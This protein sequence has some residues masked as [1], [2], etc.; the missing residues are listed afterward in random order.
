MKVAVLMSTYNGEKFIV[1]QL[2]SIIDQKD[3]E[4]SLFI[5]DDGS[6][7][8][9]LNIIEEYKDKHPNFYIEIITGKNLGVARSFMFLLDYV[10]VRM[11]FDYFAFADQDDY[12]FNDKISC[13][14]KSLQGNDSRPRLYMS[15]FQMADVLLNKIE[16]PLL[17]PKLK[18]ENALANNIATGCTMVFNKHL[19]KQLTKYNPRFITMH[20]Y[21]IYL[22]AV[23]INAY[24]YFDTTSHFL[25]RQHVNNV[26][27]GK[28][29][30][31]VKRWRLRWNKLFEKGNHFVSKMCSEI[32]EGY[33][34]DIPPHNYRLL[35]RVSRAKNIWNRFYLLLNMKIFG[36][37]LDNTI[38]CKLLILTGK[39]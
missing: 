17:K 21:W 35:M 8:N 32:L 37:T 18:L 20:D 38:R 5:R 39:Y 19:V 27:G 16:T 34:T 24:I 25:Y 1:E 9:T 13:A 36:T 33:A 15:Q 2:D 22:V 29:D 4:C 14:I 30:N 3:V 31:F 10:S 26:I 12:W 7:D 28:G 6:S 11:D 23:S